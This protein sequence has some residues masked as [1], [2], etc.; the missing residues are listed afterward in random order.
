MD[1]EYTAQQQAFRQEVR[2][3]LKENLPPKSERGKG[4]LG[5]WL[6]KVRAKGWVGFSWP[7]EFGGSDGGLIEQ[8]ILREEMASAKAPPL[9]ASF[10]GL[11]W[12]GP[13]I[14]QYGTQHRSRNSYPTSSTAKSPGVRVTRNQTT[15]QTSPPFNVRPCATATTNS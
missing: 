7:K 13:G 5:K 9:G 11:A 8:T 2:S 15:A 1:F 4:F 12:V 14:M 10:M 6:P 3:F